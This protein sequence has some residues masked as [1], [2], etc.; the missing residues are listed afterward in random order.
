MVSQPCGRF[1]F[2]NTTAKGVA[3]LHHIVKEGD[4]YRVIQLFGHTFEIRYGYYEERDRF[5]KYGEPVPIFPD[6]LNTPVFTLDG[7]PF[8]TAMQ[9]ACPHFS[10][11]EPC[12]TCFEC[13]HF[14]TGEDLIGICKSNQRKNNIHIP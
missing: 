8:V 1:L 12:G 3:D 7:H 6:F 2:V 10:G 5:S 9:D 11:E 13:K 4:L 14:E